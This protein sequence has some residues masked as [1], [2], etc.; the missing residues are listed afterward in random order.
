MPRK[1]SYSRVLIG[2]CFV[3][4]GSDGV[5]F[6]PNAQGVAARHHDATGHQTWV[7]V[8]MHL[9]YGEDGLNQT[10]ALDQTPNTN[11]TPR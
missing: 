6:G 9:R 2:G 1:Y 5:W 4:Y 10:D 3:C 8:C 11:A 7:D